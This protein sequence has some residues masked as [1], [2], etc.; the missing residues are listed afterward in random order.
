M[1]NYTPQECLKDIFA[2]PDPKEQ[3]RRIGQLFG[4]P[5]T[6]CLSI[7]SLELDECFRCLS[8]AHQMGFSVELTRIFYSITTQL[9][10]DLRK[11]A[12]VTLEQ[13]F[14]NFKTLLLEHTENTTTT[15]VR[16]TIG[17]ETAPRALFST[18]QA[19]AITDFMS[20]GFYSHFQA[21]RAL[22]D[23]SFTPF[24]TQYVQTVYI[25]TIIP[26]GFSL[27]DAIEV[28]QDINVED[29]KFEFEA[30]YDRNRL[31]NIPPGEAVSL[32]TKVLKILH[33]HVSNARQQSATMLAQMEQEYREKIKILQEAKAQAEATLHM[34]K[35]HRRPISSKK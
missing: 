12:R 2:L 34:S 10:N 16:K 32:N 3:R 8:F 30:T 31:E 18:E 11:K 22:L 28:P 21:Y 4:L 14:T 35:N 26:D 6:P 33:D 15:P 7:F 29:M 23:P 13:S 17:E 20:S 1:T 25:P 9:R 5:D 27:E 19:R 24:R